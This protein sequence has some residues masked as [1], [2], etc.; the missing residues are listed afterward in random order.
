M[1]FSK[2]PGKTGYFTKAYISLITIT[3]CAFL[4]LHQNML[5]LNCIFLMQGLV[6]N[7]HNLSA[8]SLLSI[9]PFDTCALLMVLEMLLSYNEPQFHNLYIKILLAMTDNHL[10]LRTVV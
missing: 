1:A 9:F 8:F 3:P 7:L 4:L 6:C 5:K 2:Y 10:T